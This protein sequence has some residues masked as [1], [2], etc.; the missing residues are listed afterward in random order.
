MA[1]SL[2]D[3]T[4]ET[5]S[6]PKVIG[7]YGL[8]GSGKS[9]LL[10]QLKVILGNDEFLYFEGS[11]ELASLCP[12]NNLNHFK[13][14]QKREQDRL[15]EEAVKGIA[16]KCKEAGKVGMVAG[17]FMVWSSDETS[18]TKVVTDADWGV[19]THVLYL[20]TP[21]E[22][23]WQQV[24]DD[25]SRE[26]REPLSVQVL[27][28]WQDRET[29]GLRTGCS[30]NNILFTV[31]S[32]DRTGRAERVAKLMLTLLSH[33]EADGMGAVSAKLNKVLPTHQT[34]VDTILDIDGDKTLIAND[35]SKLFWEHTRDWK[36]APHPAKILFDEL[37]DGGYSYEAFLKAALFYE[38]LDNHGFDELCDKVAAEVTVRSEFV[39][40]LKEVAKTPRLGVVI[41]SAGLRKVFEKVLKRAGLSDAVLEIV[42]AGPF[43]DDDSVVVTP[44]LKAEVVKYL[45]TN[46]NLRVWAFGDS[47][48]DI[49][50]LLQADRAIVVVGEG[51]ST[52][53]DGKLRPA[54]DLNGL[55]ARQLLVPKTATPR[56]DTTS[57]P[58]ID[59]DG[60]HFLL[61]GS[62][63]V[64]HATGKN[65]AKLLMRPTRDQSVQ[66]PALREAHHRVGQYLATEYVSEIVGLEEDFITSVQGKS[67]PGHWLRG[68]AT[69]LIVPLMRGGEPMAFGVS[70]V[71]PLATFVHAKK[72]GDLTTEHMQH[73]STIILVDSVINS[74]KSILDFLRHIRGVRTRVPVIVVA[75]VVQADATKR[76]SAFA[77]EI[78]E[79]GRVDLVAL[80]LSENKYTGKGKTDT[81]A[82]LLNT[83]QLE[84]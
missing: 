76:D 62:L 41:A 14:L 12:D 70:E 47:P 32:G 27:Q 20:A 45:K 15:R 67:T 28:T 46:N 3:A 36:R 42:G 81:G 33:N 23:I 22:V 40:I 57:L 65:A 19:Y 83:V 48:I 79:L 29:I 21:A 55:K 77:A 31:V 61:R 43:G 24:D 30:R 1:T 66:G 72:P 6:K 37:F 64:H 78:F 4:N 74:G 8:P 68:E 17:H 52:T 50:M 75:G 53:M 39:Q 9:T 13:V 82:R 80:R 84:E 11:E 25:S 7:V 51:G 38:E 56:L 16:R 34:T 2:I 73:A 44:E 59:L 71:F 63:V 49:P 5:E 18:P 10:K 69:A 35:T 26:D 58:P 54:I 60:I